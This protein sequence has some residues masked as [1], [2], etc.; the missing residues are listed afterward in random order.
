MP[1]VPQR[2]AVADDHTIFRSGLKAILKLREDIVVVAETGCADD[3]TAMLD[4]TPCDVLL[5]DLQMDRNTTA[6]IATLAQRVAVIVLTADEDPTRAVTA[7]R[8]GARA[9]VFKRFTAETLVEAL[10]A[11]AAGHVWTP[12]AIQERLVAGFQTSC[13]ELTLREREVVRWVALGLHNAEVG[14]KLFISEQT[15]KTHL[16]NIFH[17]LGVRDRVELTLYAVRKGLVTAGDQPS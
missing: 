7:L 9:V 5:L 2:I 13:E 1:N 15:V 8:S 17:K 3:I 14:R 11:V 6:D 12:P 16:N 4:R 10:H